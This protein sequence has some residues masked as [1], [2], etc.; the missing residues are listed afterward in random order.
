MDKEYK[1]DTMTAIA[2]AFLAFVIRYT[3]KEKEAIC[4][5]MQATNQS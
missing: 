4:K 3:K 2:I 1:A 5:E